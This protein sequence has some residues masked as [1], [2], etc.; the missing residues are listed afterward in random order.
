MRR[1][2]YETYKAWVDIYGGSNIMTERQYEQART[3]LKQELKEQGRSTTNLSRQLA[4][5]SSFTYGY[6]VGRAIKQAYQEEG[7]G[8][9]SISQARNIMQYD[10]EGKALKLE[11]NPE[12]WNKVSDIYKQL[13]KEGYSTAG[14]K[15]IIATTVFGS[16]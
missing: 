10:A 15:D 6:N 8:K 3:L 13:K 9:I 7:L 12:F 16:P 2:G 1:S 4:Q 11:I 5:E 14:A